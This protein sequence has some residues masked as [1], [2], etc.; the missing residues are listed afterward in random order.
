MET[1]ELISQISRADISADERLE[2]LGEIMKK[3]R[4]G[5]IAVSYTHLIGCFD[6]CTYSV[7]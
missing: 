2:A 4:S 3:V 7:I 5:E 1:N 6:S